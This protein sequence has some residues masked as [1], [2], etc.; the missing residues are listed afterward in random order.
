MLVLGVIMLIVVYLVAVQGAVEMTRTQ[1]QRSA[2]TQDNAEAVA[3]LLTLALAANTAPNGTLTLETPTA[4]KGSFTRVALPAGH[5]FWRSAPLLKPLP[6]DEL[7]TVELLD[8]PAGTLHT[9]FLVNRQGMRPGAVTLEYTAIPAPK[10]KI[11]K[12]KSKV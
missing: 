6:G 10:A 2:Q 8:T 5:E 9:R 3:S 12:P 1:G 11:A 4:H 7:L